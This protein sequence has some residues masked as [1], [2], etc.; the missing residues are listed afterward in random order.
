MSDEKRLREIY[1]SLSL[2]EF[3]TYI[4]SEKNKFLR[5]FGK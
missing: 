1:H 4:G 5:L 3:L 2:R